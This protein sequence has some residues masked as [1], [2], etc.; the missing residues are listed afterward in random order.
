MLTVT[1]SAVHLIA[2]SNP[3]S[4]RTKVQTTHYPSPALIRPPLFDRMDVGV[5]RARALRPV[6]RMQVNPRAVVGNCNSVRAVYPDQ[7]RTDRGTRRS[8]EIA[9]CGHKLVRPPSAPK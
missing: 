2:A 5:L 8:G 3:S 9:L 6:D 1:R 7:A 4:C